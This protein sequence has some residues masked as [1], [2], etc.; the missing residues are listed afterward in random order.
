MAAAA[1]ELAERYQRRGRGDPTLHRWLAIALILVGVAL[2]ILAAADGDALLMS[3]MALIA[4]TNVAQLAFNPV[5]RPK[6]VARSLEASRRV[7]VAG[8]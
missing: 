4:L 3:A 2:A 6:N 1:V 7:S 5:L 8:S